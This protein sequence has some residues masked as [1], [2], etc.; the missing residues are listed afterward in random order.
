MG[1]FFYKKK[2]F[3]RVIQAK[4]YKGEAIIKGILNEKSFHTFT[5]FIII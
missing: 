1:G 4:P 5:D 3:A 2:G